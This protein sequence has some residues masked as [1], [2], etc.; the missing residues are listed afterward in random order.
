MAYRVAK[1]SA[2]AVDNSECREA[3][4]GDIGQRAWWQAAKGVIVEL[5]ELKERGVDNMKKS[6]KRTSETAT[7]WLVNDWEAG[8]ALANPRRKSPIAWATL[9]DEEK[10]TSELVIQFIL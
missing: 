1:T 5:N 3:S 8:A 4:G 10:S 6:K 7:R 2:R 9:K